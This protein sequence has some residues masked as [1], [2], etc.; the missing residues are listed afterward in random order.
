MDDEQ[1]MSECADVAL[2]C[3]DG[4]VCLGT[5]WSCSRASPVL[6][7]VLALDPEA[8]DAAGRAVY[9]VPRPS[10][11]LGLC[12]ALMHGTRCVGDLD[13]ESVVRARATLDYLAA[14]ALL[15]ECTSRAWELLADSDLA[16]LRPWLP[17]LLHS[18]H[19]LD[20]LR[21]LIGLC[22][23]FL[24]FTAALE[25]VRVDA[26]L[27]ALVAGR[28]GSYFPPVLL[29]D[30]AASRLLDAG[31]LDAAGRVPGGAELVAA[32]A[33][34]QGV[35]SHPAEVTDS[36]EIV[37]RWLPAPSRQL[38]VN[39]MEGMHVVTHEPHAGG[40]TCTVVDYHEPAISVLVDVR[41]AWGAPRQWRKV[42]PW[43]TLHWGD[44]NFDAVGGF[45]AQVTLAKTR[46]A[47]ACAARRMDARV[48]AF[49]ADRRV[50]Y[51]RWATVPLLNPRHP[52]R[53]T[54]AHS[55]YTS[56][57]EA[58]RAVRLRVDIFFGAQPVWSSPY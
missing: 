29:L 14:E 37:H 34:R 7:E 9:A 11:S 3:A 39:W 49:A 23:G 16:G 42:L 32:L 44:P 12:L 52:A 50:V 43:L 2:R 56:P 1:L 38:V 10:D 20:V 40:L 6:R 24:P 22:I 31:V 48:L 47:G 17:E 5:R 19:A 30:W 4:G 8:R 26:R 45:D 25:D 51:E 13:L 41:G 57:R 33:G 21:R 18:P 54:A 27:A 15:A 28:L 58:G 46:D 55:P 53:L 35:Y 36:M